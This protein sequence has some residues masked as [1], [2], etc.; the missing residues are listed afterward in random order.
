MFGVELFTGEPDRPY[1]VLGTLT[2]KQDDGNIAECNLILIELATEWGADGV[3]NIKYNRKVSWTSWSQLVATGTA[4]KFESREKTCPDCAESVKRDAK[5]CRF[6]GYEFIKSKEAKTTQ[7]K[8]PRTLADLEGIIEQQ[9][10]FDNTKSYDVSINEVGKDSLQTIRVI[11]KLTNYSIEECR[12]LLTSLPALV[13]EN[14]TDIEI[15]RRAEKLLSEVGCKVSLRARP[16][17]Y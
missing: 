8:H 17:T 9:S 4:V 2:A 12:R 7:H 10:D 13:L 15:A 5:K 16:R 11:R 14:E 3:I 1:R 6:C